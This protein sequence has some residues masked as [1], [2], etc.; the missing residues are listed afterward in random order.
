MQAG[1]TALDEEEM[2]LPSQSIVA[3]HNTFR[4]VQ[5]EARTHEEVSAI[6]AGI[7]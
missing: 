6:M 4:F 5:Y 2:V 3:V 1:V 7:S